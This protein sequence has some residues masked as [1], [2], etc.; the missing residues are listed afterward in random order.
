MGP[1]TFSRE[2]REEFARDR[3]G[4]VAAMM[5][6]YAVLAL[7]PMLLFVV[8]VALLVV[9]EHALGQGV[10]M[11]TRTVPGQVGS[12]IGAEILRM[13]Q[14]A[15]GGFAITGAALALWAASRGAVSLGR[16]LNDIQGR[17]ERRPWWKVQVTA[18][19]VTLAIALLLVVALGLLVAAPALGRLVAARFGLGGAF[20]VAWSIGRWVGAALLVLLVMAIAY[21][22]LPDGDRRF[23]LFTPGA[24]VG[25]AFWLAASLGFALYVRYFGRYERTYGAIGAVVVFLLWLWLSNLAL[26]VGAEID[27]VRARAREERR[28]HEPLPRPAPA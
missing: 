16:A 9:P 2:L 23:R 27:E 26:L 19:A 14:A 21:R 7:F 15:G 3:V 4:D 10:A 1:R 24:I 13:K 6:Y 25:L 8:M 28:A 12:L 20:E 17:P 11:A 5:T 18:V 22:W